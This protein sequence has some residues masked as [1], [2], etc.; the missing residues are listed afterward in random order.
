MIPC[1]VLFHL[2]FNSL[3]GSFEISKELTDGEL[4]LFRRFPEGFVDY[5]FQFIGENQVLPDLRHSRRRIGDRFV[6]KLDEIR[7]QKR[8]SARKHLE[9]NDTN[10][11]EIA[12][13]IEFE[14]LTL[15]RTHVRRTACY[16]FG[17]AELGSGCAV[18]WCIGN[19]EIENLGIIAAT[20][21]FFKNDVFGFHVSV[22]ETLIVRV[23]QGFTDLTSN[24][25]DARDR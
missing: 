2:Y 16:C 19:T 11:I 21:V 7:S 4:S 18:R 5:C 22:D 24:V 12:S 13:K 6:H 25:D 23:R 9:Y 1:A 15:L 8:S 14:T 20:L 10:R 17:L 3:A